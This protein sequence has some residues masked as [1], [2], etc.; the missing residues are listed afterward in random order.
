LKSELDV[1]T[2]D[3]DDDESSSDESDGESIDGEIIEKFKEI[4]DTLNDQDD[5]IGQ[6]K[7]EINEVRN[8]HTNFEDRT[9]F[10][11]RNRT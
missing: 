9:R 3:E 6:L 5:L 4:Q 8:M 2:D 7:D 10:E 1:I 11:T